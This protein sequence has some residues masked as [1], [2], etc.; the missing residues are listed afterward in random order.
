MFIYEHKQHDNLTYKTLLVNNKDALSE[1]EK[2]LYRAL[3]YKKFCAGSGSTMLRE[4][5]CDEHALD[6]LL[7]IYHG[8]IPNVPTLFFVS[9]DEAMLSRAYGSIE[10]WRLIH[11]NYISD[12]TDG[13]IVY[14]DCGHYVHAENPDEVS[15]AMK[16][17]IE[18]PDRRGKCFHLT[19]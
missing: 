8:P 4:M 13:A 6:V 7:K 2:K 14:L 18:S 17:F 3:F 11:D 12:V 16:A 19:K 5:I 15:R 10:N 9:Y 1:A